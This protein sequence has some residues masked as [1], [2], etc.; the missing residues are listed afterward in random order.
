KRSSNTSHPR[1]SATPAGRRRERSLG[2]LGCFVKAPTDPILIQHDINAI[3]VDLD[4][5]D[6][7]AHECTEAFDPSVMFLLGKISRWLRRR[8]RGIEWPEGWRPGR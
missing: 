1:S 2:L 4:T 5:H 3:R 8:K 6:A 7:D